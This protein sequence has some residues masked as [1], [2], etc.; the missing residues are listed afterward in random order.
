MQNFMEKAQRAKGGGKNLQ[1]KRIDWIFEHL[2]YSKKRERE[3]TPAITF[4]SKRPVLSWWVQVHFFNLT[5][6]QKIATN[7]GFERRS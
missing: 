4:S 7:H 5:C 1:S 6:A 2:H 3:Q